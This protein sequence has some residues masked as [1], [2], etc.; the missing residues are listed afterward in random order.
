MNSGLG[1]SPGEGSSG[2][3]SLGQGWLW[4]AVFVAIVLVLL[5]IPAHN[6]TAGPL[7]DLITG[8]A[9]LYAAGLSIAAVRLL[10]GVIL[11]LGGSRDP[12]VLLGSG[13]DPLTS[14]VVGARWRLAAVVAGLV[15]PAAVA[16]V[17]GSTAAG[18][19]P[20][21]PAHAIATLV[22]GVNVVVSAGALV[23]APGFPGWA[24]A[25]ALADGTGASVDQRLWR[26]ARLARAVGVP[27][28]LG[29]TLLAA[30]L[31]DPMLM[32]LGIVFAFLT[33]SGG[34]LAAG[35][36]ATARFLAG[37]VA[38]DLARPITAQAAP[39]EPVAGLLACLRMATF[40]ALIEGDGGIVGAIGPRQLAG[41]SGARLDDRCAALMV[42][43][44]S[45]RL[46]GPT[47]AAVDVLPEL[48][49]H[50]FALVRE[51]DGLG[52]VEAQDLGRQVRIWLDLR[53]R[54]SALAGRPHGE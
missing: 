44:E 54:G 1:S 52:Y 5:Y 45:L 22:L 28:L 25:L 18:L 2:S 30:L 33:W 50:G 8:T 34:Q 26:A 7:G 14:P 17:A 20:A 42:P 39:D 21:A 49:R 6:P 46:F 38:G 3:L 51:T 47:A 43:L 32:V 37:H 16:V 4:P 13:P 27:I 29:V 15:G 48:A 31:G 40:V 10:R 53:E 36:D 12:I 19:D 35:Q 24:L 41:V 9:L 23:L 11:R